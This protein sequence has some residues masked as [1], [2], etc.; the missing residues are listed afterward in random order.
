M[1]LLEGVLVRKLYMPVQLLKAGSLAKADELIAD[2]AI[3]DEAILDGVQLVN[4]LHNHLKLI[5][6]KVLDNS[7]SADVNT[8]TNVTVN[9]KG[10]CIV[11]ISRRETLDGELGLP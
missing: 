3:L 2:E 8:K 10:C 1:L 5:L 6:Y 9:H 4:V 7:I 11:H